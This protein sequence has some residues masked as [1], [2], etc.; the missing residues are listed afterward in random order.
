MYKLEKQK[1]NKL[2]DYYYYFKRNERNKKIAKSGS[3][4]M[5]RFSK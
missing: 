2:E 3:K 4:M 1:S 5:E